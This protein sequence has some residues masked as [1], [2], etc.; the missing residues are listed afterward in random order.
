QPCT[1]RS[2]KL[3]RIFSCGRSVASL[4]GK[5]QL[6]LFPGWR[7]AFAIACRLA[8]AHLHLL[9]GAG[10]SE[11]FCARARRGVLDSVSERATL[12]QTGVGHVY[13]L[14]AGEPRGFCVLG[15][16][17]IHAREARNLP[18]RKARG[19][20]FPESRNQLDSPAGRATIFS[21]WE[22]YVSHAPGGLPFLMQGSR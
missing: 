16:R 12:P 3:W 10:S 14:C 4:S 18:F 1:S 20:V 8:R 9:R 15:R 7:G 6:F 17:R 2:R 21:P 5:S 19:I 11:F 13:S 22:A